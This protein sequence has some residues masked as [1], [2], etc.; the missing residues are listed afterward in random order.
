MGQ[1][2]KRDSPT[3]HSGRNSGVAGE[4]E[5]NGRSEGEGENDDEDEAG[6]LGGLVDNRSGARQEV[7]QSAALD[8]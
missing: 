8:E 5:N 3:R 7:T 4:E 2:R 6:G 1:A